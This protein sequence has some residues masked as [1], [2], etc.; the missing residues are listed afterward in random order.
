MNSLNLA[1]V[2]YR[3]RGSRDIMSGW[4]ARTTGDIYAIDDTGAGYVLEVG[5]RPAFKVGDRLRF[6]RPIDLHPTDYIAADERAHVVEVD[7]ETGVVSLWVEG[8]HIGLGDGVPVL[9]ISPRDDV[10]AASCIEHFSDRRWWQLKRLGV[11]GG[12]RGDLLALSTLFVTMPLT[13]ILHSI[14]PERPSTFFFVMAVVWSALV[15]GPRAAVALSLVTPLAFNL[16]CPPIGSLVGF[17][18]EDGL[19]LLMELT[20]AAAF[21]WLVSKGAAKLNTVVDY[22]KQH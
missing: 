7:A 1:P 10:E 12:V 13:A 3:A 6:T 20:I 4:Q 22:V 8:V 2:F 11:I 21:P 17:T 14:A 5:A 16:V 19:V 18:F 9:K 15:L